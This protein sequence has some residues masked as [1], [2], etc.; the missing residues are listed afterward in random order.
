[1][2]K[3]FLSY[4]RKDGA[5]AQRLTAWLEH[6][7]HD[8]WRDEDDIGGGAS[9]S[10]E[11]EKAL[12]ECDAVLVLW[13]ADSVQS[14][15]V[16]DEAGYGR[17]AGKLIPFSLDG[18]EAPLGFRQFQAISLSAWTGR[19]EPPHAERIRRAIARIAGHGQAVPA[20]HPTT[21]RRPGIALRRPL[22]AGGALALL[23]AAVLGIFLWERWSTNRQIS[24]AVLPSPTSSDRT[25]AVD[26]ANVAAA[27]MA[28]FLPRRFDRATV[29][30]PADASGS[31]SSYRMQ[32]STSSHGAGV[33]A[34]LTLSDLDG[35]TTLWS[36]NWSV[37]DA[38]GADLKAQISAAASKA[39]LCLTDARG[40]SPRLTQP[41]L[42][43]YLAG[44]TGMGDTKLSDVD[45]T[46]IFDRVTKLEPRFSS[47]WA[48]LALSEVNAAQDQPNASPAAY[49]AALQRARQAIATALRL[50]P[51]SAQA[52]HAEY[53]LVA[54]DQ[55]RAFK[56][57]GKAIE[58]APNDGLLQMH[59]SDQLFLVG[60]V[61]DS[62]Q[63]SQRAVELDPGSP[64]V[65]A[66]YI[67]TLAFSGALPKARAE[68]AEARKRWPSDPQ[69]DIAEFTLEYRYGDPRAALKLLPRITDSSEA[70]MAPFR[71][72][73]A[74]RLDP[75]PSTIDQ[76]IAALSARAPNDPDTRNTV[77]RTLGN[78]GR[79][80][81][82]YQFLEDPR[83]QPYVDREALFRPDFASVRADPRFMRVA[84]QLGLVRYWRETGSWPDFCTTE[85]LPYDCK[86]EAAKY[87]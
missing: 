83:F 50:N 68:I 41:A 43:L 25:M 74:A 9:F 8:V 59:M 84:A 57:I 58:L 45:F 32:V 23:A 47:G 72:V 44:C 26:Y 11:I 40:G 35:R 60:R 63:A 75:N 14:A 65:R 12:N 22:L 78:L 87:P 77:V 3:L 81:Q 7:G 36:Q 82:V 20:P 48:Y 38:A 4:S 19:R 55:L 79:V 5:K 53:H 86:A 69:I 31:G 76:A 21:S 1:V 73:I 46:D 56:V 42:G 10:S 29:I 64:F 24:I 15:W 6:D 67:A 27:D 13:S 61:S 30:A 71:K 49:A 2:A 85:R 62:V 18:T 80:E 51:N 28:A 39:A 37:A 52:Y 34:S 16:R 33:D 17:D 66:Q 54:K 70:S